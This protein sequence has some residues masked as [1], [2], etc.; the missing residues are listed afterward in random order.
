MYKHD[1]HSNNY[2]SIWRCWECR[3]NRRVGKHRRGFPNLWLLPFGFAA[4][5]EKLRRPRYTNHEKVIGA[6]HSDQ[7][8]SVTQLCLTLCN[9]ISHWWFRVGFY[10]QIHY[11]LGMGFCYRANLRF[12]PVYWDNWASLEAQTVKHLSAMLETRVRSLGWDDPL[13]KEM[14]THSSILAWKTPWTEEPG[15]L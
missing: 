2:I 1:Y 15:R 13:E 9:P 14:A 12:S 10:S 3:K 6:N 11:V 5:T 7:F 8:S 4:V